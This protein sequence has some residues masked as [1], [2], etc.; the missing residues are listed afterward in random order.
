SD[1]PPLGGGVPGGVAGPGSD[2]RGQSGAPPPDQGNPL[3][4][5]NTAPLPPQQPAPPFSFLGGL[6]QMGRDG[7]YQQHQQREQQRQQDLINRWKTGALE[8]QRRSMEQ[9]YGPVSD[10]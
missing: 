4:P 5:V 7:Q 3:P 9:Q 10:E 6:D 2:D 8:E 1:P